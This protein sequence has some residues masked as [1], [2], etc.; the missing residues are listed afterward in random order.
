MNC[1]SWSFSFQTISAKCLDIERNIAAYVTGA[2]PLALVGTTTA[3][4]LCQASFHACFCDM[5]C[6][7]RIFSRSFL[8]PVL[9]LFLCVEA[10]F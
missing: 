2:R 9:C 8:M 1:S 3:A 7:S 10:C 4:T 6:E 5:V